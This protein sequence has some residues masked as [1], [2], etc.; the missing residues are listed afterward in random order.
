MGN[1]LHYYHFLGKLWYFGTES[2][3][4]QSSALHIKSQNIYEF[5]NMTLHD[6]I[7]DTLVLCVWVTEGAGSK[8]CLHN[9]VKNKSPKVNAPTKIIDFHYYSRSVEK[10][11]Q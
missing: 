10:K 8:G 4:C 2:S 11:F 1:Y 3:E 9:V 7:W 6:Y 5:N